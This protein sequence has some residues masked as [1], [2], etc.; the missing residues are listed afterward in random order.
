MPA[1]DDDGRSDSG[2]DAPPL[3]RAPRR[4]RAFCGHEREL[5]ALRRWVE[6]LLPAC[7]ARYD[8][9]LAASEL[10]SNAIA[11]TASGRGGWFAAEITWI[12]RAVRVAVSDGGSISEPLVIDDLEAERGRGLRMIHGLAERTG[13]EGDCQGRRVCLLYTSPSPRD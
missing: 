10:A 1:S 8:V 4:G 12:E 7:P 2:E 6:S 9:I 13:V 11:H 3:D 5:A